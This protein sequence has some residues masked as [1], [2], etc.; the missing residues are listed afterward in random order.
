MPFPDTLTKPYL[1]QT[2]LLAMPSPD[3]RDMSPQTHL[4]AIPPQADLPV[5]PPPNRLIIY[6][7]LR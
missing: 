3:L 2:D 7:S 1:L 5:I 4:P 6:D